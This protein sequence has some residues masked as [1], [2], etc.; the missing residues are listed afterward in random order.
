MTVPET[1]AHFWN[2]LNASYGTAYAISFDHEVAPWGKS[3]TT[4]Q[5]PQVERAGQSPVAL[6]S[7][8]HAHNTPFN[9]VCVLPMI[10]LRCRFADN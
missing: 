3:V 4:R 10:N 9:R 7:R 1:S 6:L 2:Q 5:I 8:K